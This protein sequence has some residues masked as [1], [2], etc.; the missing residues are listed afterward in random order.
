MKI[1]DTLVD[2]LH[3]MKEPRIRTG[4]ELPHAYAG[5]GGGCARK[6][7]YDLL[8][9][10]PGWTP[11]LT[12]EV[13]FFLGKQIELAVL[14]AARL[15]NP[16][17]QVQVPW[18]SDEGKIAGIADGLYLQLDEPQRLARQELTLDP[19][20]SAP[21]PRTGEK[22]VIEVKSMAQTY[23]TQALREGPK[24]DN[25]VQ[26]CLSARALGATW[27][28]IVYVSKGA[29]ST[30]SPITEWIM[31]ADWDLTNLA[32]EELIMAVDAAREGHSVPPWVLGDL[33]MYPYTKRPPCLW[34]S[35]VERCRADPFDAAAVT[36]ERMARKS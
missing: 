2:G 16:T 12:Q 31:P 21:G 5:D 10:R 1:A 19:V 29:K 35:H 8:E 15:Q 24:I 20:E 33:I 32:A 17:L 27:V 22:V 14:E 3:S 18:V 34:C 9:H 6:V 11:N 26:A 13:A 30:E 4:A 28:H 25:V 23:Y 7:S 36:A